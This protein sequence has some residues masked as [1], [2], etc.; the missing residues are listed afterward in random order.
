MH[1]VM[2]ERAPCGKMAAV[3]GCRA[4]LAS[5]ADETSS[6]YDIYEPGD[7]QVGGAYAASRRDFRN[8]QVGGVYAVSGRSLC[9]NPQAVIAEDG[10]E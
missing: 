6:L 4:P 1:H 9:G 7:L 10:G 8:V 5:S 2:S 3:C